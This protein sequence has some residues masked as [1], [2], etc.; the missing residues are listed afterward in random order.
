MGGQFLAFDLFHTIGFMM[1]G[2]LLLLV[3]LEGWTN[4]RIRMQN[5]RRARH[6]DPELG[7]EPVNPNVSA[8]FRLREPDTALRHLHFHRVPP[9]TI[10]WT[11]SHLVG[12]PP[13]KE[14]LHIGR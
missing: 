11:G 8:G 7:P 5:R 4:L 9:R 14:E 2:G 13:A 12:R 6:P 3:C 10:S 1:F